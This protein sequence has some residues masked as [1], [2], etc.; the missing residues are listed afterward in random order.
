MAGV[1]THYLTPP[2]D[3]GMRIPDQMLDCVGFISH[4]T[5]TI[6]YGGTVFLV[7]TVGTF[8]NVF[9]HLVTARHVAE[10][11]DPG[12][13]VVGFNGK[14]GGK[15]LIKS[16]EGS[17]WWY[18]P[19]ERESV[20][21]AVTLFATEEI[22]EYKLQWIPEDMFVTDERMKEYHIGIGDQV[23]VVGLFTRFSGQKK[24]IPIVRTGNLAMVP[25]EPIPVK[26]FGQMEAYL[27]EGRSIGGLS[28]SPVFVRNTVG[29]PN[30]FDLQKKPIFALVMGQLHFL[31]LMHGHWDVPTNFNAGQQLEWV[32]MG[33]SI[34][35]PAKKILETIN[36]PEIVEMRNEVD[37]QIAEENAPT[38]DSELGEREEKPFTKQ[39]FDA[40]L[41]KVSRKI[42]Q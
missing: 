36:H 41:R 22:A 38:A 8:G 24:H 35:V 34:I 40:A 33:V 14:N 17:R 29:L 13:F 32:N 15:I 23:N 25:D 19:T 20:D 42:E 28:G 21:V 3:F 2:K 39:D 30:L 16:A 6:K 31:G 18:H 12:N 10:K 26:D 9:L 1:E 5:P 4:D 27:A 7:G 11:I 37:R